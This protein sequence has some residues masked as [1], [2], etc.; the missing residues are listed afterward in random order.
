MVVIRRF[1]GRQ[2]HSGRGLCR[3]GDRALGDPIGSGFCRT[4]DDIALVAG[5][6][7]GSAEVESLD[8]SV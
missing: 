4:G 6:S 7:L 1:V 8:D 2:S 5:S 3:T